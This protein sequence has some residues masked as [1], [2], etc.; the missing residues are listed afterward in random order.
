MFQMS[1][2]NRSKGS[3][4]AKPDEQKGQDVQQKSNVGQQ[5]PYDKGKQNKQGNAAG[6]GNQGD[7]VMPAG[8]ET[9]G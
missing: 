6:Q 8:R 9:P 4:P 7:D 3:G 2:K 1:D 5:I